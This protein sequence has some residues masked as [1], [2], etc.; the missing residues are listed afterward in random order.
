MT[1]EDEAVLQATLRFYDALEQLLAGKGLTAMTDAW[2]HT[3]RVTSGHPTG[4]WAHGWDEVLATWEVFSSYG[5]PENAGTKVRDVKVY[6]YGDIAYT[7]CVFTAAPS[8][9]SA[10][11]SC[12]NVLHCVDGAWKIIHHHADKAPSVEAGLEK[13]AAD[14]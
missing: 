14:S 5:K 7:T 9:G 11:M 13:M 8:F 12:T 4:E 3:P 6:R 10:R 1:T 2:H